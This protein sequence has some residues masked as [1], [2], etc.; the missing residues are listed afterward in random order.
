MGWANRLTIARG[1]LAI[2]LWGVLHTIA[3]GYHEVTSLW[4]IA[5]WIFVV[6]AA[7]DSLD[8]YIARKLNEVS[9]FGRI[10]DPL[11]DKLLILGSLL[12]LLGIPGVPPFLPPWTAA[13]ILGRE[14]LITALRGSIEA[15]GKNFQAGVWG[16][17]KMAVQCIAVGA[18]MLA[19]A[20]V[21]FVRARL[22]D[23]PVPPAGFREVTLCWLLCVLAALIT[24]LSGIEYVKRA[25]PL[26]RD[27]PGG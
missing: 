4:W 19:G 16:K 7:T 10:A 14:L 17:A 15:R 13:V 1:V 25:L 18:V 27:E 12:F 3:I 5:F 11:V 6:A 2:V 23:V 22:F 8:G 26:L 9:V 24:I 21:P 20:G